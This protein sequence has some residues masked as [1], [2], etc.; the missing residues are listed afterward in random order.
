MLKAKKATIYE[1]SIKKKHSEI[2]SYVYSSSAHSAL[3]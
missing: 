1:G 2:F 3:G